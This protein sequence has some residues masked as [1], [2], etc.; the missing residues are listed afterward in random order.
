LSWNYNKKC[1]FEIRAGLMGTTYNYY[2]QEL[3][4]RPTRKSGVDLLSYWAPKNGWGGARS[5]APPVL[6][7]FALD[8]PLGM[9]MIFSGGGAYSTQ[10]FSCLYTKIP[11][12]WRTPHNFFTKS[13][14]GMIDDGDNGEYGGANRAFYTYKGQKAA[15]LK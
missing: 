11:F 15:L 6:P 1:N 10:K 9:Y 14:I 12:F 5:S 7:Y 3:S 8:K 2:Y 4:T 13:A